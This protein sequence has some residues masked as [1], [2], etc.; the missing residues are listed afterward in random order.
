[1]AK[2]KPTKQAKH[3]IRKANVGDIIKSEKFAH[4]FL[5]TG[6]G[7][8]DKFISIGGTA[9]EPYLFRTRDYDESRGLAEFVVEGIES[10]SIGH[11]GHVRGWNVNARRLHKTGTYNPYGE[12]IQ[13]DQFGDSVYVVKE[14][15]LVGKMR[16][17]FVRVK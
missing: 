11:D 8:R 17:M 10:N 1:M 12:I 5:Y 4:G 9:G 3:M 15:E 16:R 14:V 13:F 7:L 2:T 6:G